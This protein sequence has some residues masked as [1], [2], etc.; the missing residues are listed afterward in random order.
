MRIELTHTV[1]HDGRMYTKGDVL[2]VDDG[3]GGYFCHCGWAKD[4]SGQVATGEPEQDVTLDV[5]SAKHKSRASE[6]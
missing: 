4:V 3:L 2:T 6:A 5:H 1:K